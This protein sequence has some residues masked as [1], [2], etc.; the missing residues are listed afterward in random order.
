MF[1]VLSVISIKIRIFYRN[2]TVIAEDGGR[3]DI[4]KIKFEMRQTR[5]RRRE[6]KTDK[7]KGDG[8]T[9]I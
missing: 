4:D 5:S 9:E 3:N 2:K 6:G 1:W 8:R 7:A